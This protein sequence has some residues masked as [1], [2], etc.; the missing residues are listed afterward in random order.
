[1]NVGANGVGVF[2]LDTLDNLKLVNKFCYLGDILRKGGGAEEASRSRV[3]FA[4]LLILSEKFNET[5]TMKE[6]LY[7]GLSGEIQ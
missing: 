5:W 7:E 6:K 3:K 1:V 2:I 4:S